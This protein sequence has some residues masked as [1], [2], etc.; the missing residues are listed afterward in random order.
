M[1][2]PLDDFAAI[3]EEVKNVLQDKDNVL[4]SDTDDFEPQITAALE[5][6][7]NNFP[8]K[9][10]KD[11]AGDG[12]TFQFN[13]TD[14]SGSEWK[15]EFSVIK[16]IELPTGQR[17]PS[18][19]RDLDYTVF[20]GDPD[21]D[22]DLEEVL[23]ILS[24]TPSATETVRIVH[25][26]LHTIKDLLS[27]TATTLDEN[28][29]YA[30]TFLAAAYCAEAIARHLQRKASASV[31][32]DVLS[33]GTQSD[34]WETRA[35]TLRKKYDNGVGKESAAGTSLQIGFEKTTGASDLTGRI[36]RKFG[37]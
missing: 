5:E 13:L 23:Q 29:R 4:A 32:E 24:T 31:G 21:D 1:P 34:Q 22:G 6:H 28:H 35:E 20:Q 8:R 18:F 16:S 3:L 33:F 11:F 30:F 17:P 7:S 14:A 9:V 12:S 27:A 19:L 15:N 2:P 25:T 26:A 36:A 10:V 37:Y